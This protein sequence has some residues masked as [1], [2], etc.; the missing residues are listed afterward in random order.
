ML[1][2]K[3]LPRMDRVDTI[4]GKETEFKG[5]VRSQGVL[6]VDGKVEGEISHNGDV[7]VGEHGSVVANIRARHVA[8]AGEVRGNIEAD[9]RLEL[10]SSARLHGDIRVGQLVV[11]DG[12][13]FQGTSMM[14]TSD[15]KQKP[16]LGARERN[17]RQ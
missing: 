15:E 13:Q 14:R 12:A 6:R 9:G 8:I 7:V 17:E 3:K 10:V 5:T 2:R 1:G 11:A 4:I 16:T